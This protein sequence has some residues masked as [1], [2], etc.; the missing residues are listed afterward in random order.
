MQEL[1]KN[2]RLP[3]NT[4][5]FYIS[6]VSPFRVSK[7]EPK[8]DLR[9]LRINSS[10]VYNAGV[11]S[12]VCVKAQVRAQRDDLLGSLSHSGGNAILNGKKMNE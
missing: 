3:L 7:T 10:D 6:A 4:N 8:K 9:D 5:E 12:R 1:L 11:V 2:K